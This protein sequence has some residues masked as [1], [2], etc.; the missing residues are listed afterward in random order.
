[1][2][3]KAR[4]QEVYAEIRKQ[5]KQRKEIKDLFKNELEHHER[6]GKL[7]EEMDVLRQ[8]KKSIET[9]VRETSPSESLKLQDIEIELKANEELLSDLAFNLLM[10][11][12]NIELEDEFKNRYVPQ[13]LVKFKKEEAGA[14]D[15]KKSKE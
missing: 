14:E 7:K 12:E 6:Y 9:Q 1:M 10:K 13:F 4:L 15:A 11:D 2:S 8:E 5:K 3:D